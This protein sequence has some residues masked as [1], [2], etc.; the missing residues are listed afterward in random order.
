M[1]PA[2]MLTTNN[3]YSTAATRNNYTT[4]TEAAVNDKED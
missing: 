2:M 1:D 3:L 4:C